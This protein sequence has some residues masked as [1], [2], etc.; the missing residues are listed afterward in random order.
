MAL[1]NPLYTRHLFQRVDVLRIVA[2]KLPLLIQHGYEFV[3]GGR[4]ELTGVDLLQQT[5]GVNTGSH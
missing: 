4:L 5:H 1:D 3:T 2:Q